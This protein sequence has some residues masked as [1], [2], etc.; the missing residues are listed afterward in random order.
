MPGT[1]DPRR[2]GGP[3]GRRLDAPPSR[4]ESSDLGA[5]AG[6]LA[7]RAKDAAYVAV[8]LGV[9]GLQR[10][11]VVRHRLA[12]NA[13]GADQRI[14]RLGNGLSLGAQQLADWLEGTAAFVGA[15]LRP[16]EDERPET[17]LETARELADRARAQVQAWGAQVAQAGGRRG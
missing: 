8:G 13:A 4:E 10:A 14:A 16:L 15:Q 17:A 3:G 5:L 6:E 1:Q 7:H 12:T 9:L 11:Q 2:A